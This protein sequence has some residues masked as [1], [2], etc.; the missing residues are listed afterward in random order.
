[1]AS[2]PC[3]DTGGSWYD[4]AMIAE[5]EQ[6][7]RAFFQHDPEVLAVYLFG[8][9]ARGTAGPGSDV[10]VAVLLDR[11]PEGEFP[12]V[13]L[14]LESDLELALR[15]PV[16]LIVLGR[17]P[18]DLVHRIL[19]DGRLLL[20]KDPSRRIAFEVRARNE[21]FDLQPYLHRYRHPRD[22]Q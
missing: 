1:M 10:D 22:R 3:R 15:R 5:I 21:Y 7:V 16:Q 19:R 20:D 9:F 8:S 2:A 6:S 13:G 17:A 18:A 11:E 12:G 14:R 4:P